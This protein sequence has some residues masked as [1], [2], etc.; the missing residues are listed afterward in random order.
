L[1]AEEDPGQ[2]NV[3]RLSPGFQRI[4]FKGIAV[5]AN[6]LRIKFRIHGRAAYQ[7][8]QTA[9]PAYRRV[10]HGLGG[11]RIGN[12]DADTHRFIPVALQRFSQLNRFDLIQIR[13]HHPGTRFRQGPAETPPQQTRSTSHNSGLSF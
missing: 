2:V 12:I 6:I 4:I 9:K 11:I 13:D 10:R 8:I 3:Q 1:R 7:D 5:L